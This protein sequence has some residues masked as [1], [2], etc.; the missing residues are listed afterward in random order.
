MKNLFQTIRQWQ[1]GKTAVRLLNRFD[2]HVL[3]DMGIS[4]SDIRR[5]VHIFH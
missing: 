2:D 4:R 5:D 1:R 3:G